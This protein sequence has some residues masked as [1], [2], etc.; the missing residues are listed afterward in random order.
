MEWINL[1]KL[2]ILWNPKVH[3]HVHNSLPLVPILSQM[4]P[5]HK[6]STN[7]AHKTPSDFIMFHAI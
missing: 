7:I 4:N 3:C 1:G 6:L 2:H 5:V